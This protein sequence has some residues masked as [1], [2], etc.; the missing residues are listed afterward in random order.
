MDTFSV[1]FVL[2][3]LVNCFLIYYAIS[4][5]RRLYMVATNIEALNEVFT[6]FSNHVESVHETEMFYGD[7]TL[8]AL[9]EH[10]K[11][12]LDELDSYEDLMGMVIEED[13]GEDEKKEEE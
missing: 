13:E 12:V 2:S 1:L 11:E 3:L 6:N 9:I 8:Q 10:S 5:A 7:Q 4:A